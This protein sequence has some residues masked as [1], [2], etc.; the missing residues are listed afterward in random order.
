M[1]WMDLGVKTVIMGAKIASLW[2]KKIKQ[3]LDGRRH[4]AESLAKDIKP[5]DRVVWFHAASFG[6]FEEGRPL[7]EEIRSRYPNYRILVTFF[8]PS[9]YNAHKNY[10]H[11][12][13]VT[14]LPV[15]TSRD[16]RSFLDVVHPE[17]AVFIKYEFWPNLLAELKN[18]SVR[19]FV[20]SARFIPNSRFFRW[21]GGVFRKA[22]STFETLFVQ[23]SRSIEL[24]KT[25]GITNALLAGDPRFDR[26]LSI[27]KEEWKDE[28]VD[29][30]RQ[31]EKLFIAGSTVG[32]GDEDLLQKLINKHPETLFL[33]VP[34]EMDREP[35]N[36]IVANTTGEVLIYSE[37]S[38]DTD[39]TN[40]QVL[41]VDKI[42]MLAKL[43]RYGNWA[44][45]GG[46][47]VAGIHSV[48]EATIYGM[49]AVFGPNYNKNRPGLE[50]VELGICASVSNI[51]ELDAWF[52]PL[53]FDDE[54]LQ[55]ISQQARDYSLKNCGATEIILNKIFND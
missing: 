26:V 14:Y 45:I 27:S 16:V 32:A 8:S 12:D 39:F 24:L 28:I 19:T 3:G 20:V 30:F 34:H 53:E 13:C 46:G 51:E 18:R 15:D 11:A 35:M 55:K 50:M 1:W 52:T 29:K 9:G 17:I 2:N 23:D 44:F 21:Y 31:D 22:L 38:S 37:C 43:Y 47:F 42:G 6:E 54:K 25:I 10:P 5:S 41:I 36:K 49:P 48:I 4:L 7:I 40:T 33:L